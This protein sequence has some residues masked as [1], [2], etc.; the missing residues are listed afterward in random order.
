MNDRIRQTITYLKE[1]TVRRLTVEIDTL[2]QN[3]RTGGGGV[4]QFENKSEKEVC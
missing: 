2:I 1:F 4:G 3:K